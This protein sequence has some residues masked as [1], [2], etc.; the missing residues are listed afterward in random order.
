MTKKAQEVVKERGLKPV[1]SEVVK[2]QADADIAKSA[3]V[4]VYGVLCERT[5]RSKLAL[6]EESP[7]LF[8]RIHQIVGTALDTLSSK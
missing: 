6:T 1:P 3:L 4:E 5:M 8:A 7:V 2:A